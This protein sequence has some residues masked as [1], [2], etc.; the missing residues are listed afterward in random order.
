MKFGICT[1]LSC[2]PSTKVDLPINSWDEVK[3][4]F[5]KWDI[6]HYTLDGD[7]WHEIELKN[8]IEDCT[9]WKRPISVTIYDA[10]TQKVIAED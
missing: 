1:T 3:E 6:L 7:N 8:K 10:E 4:W 2:A 5:V 9:D